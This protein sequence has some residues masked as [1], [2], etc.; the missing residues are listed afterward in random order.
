MINPINII[1]EIFEKAQRLNRNYPNVVVLATVSDNKPNT[2]CVLIKEINE[3]GFVFYTN[4]ESNK[5]KE[6]EKNPFVSIVFF[7]EELKTQIRIKGIAEKVSK[8]KSEEYFKSRPKG[9][10]IATIISK[11]SKELESYEKLIEEFEKLLEFYKDKEVEKPETWG[12]YIIKPFEIEIW[13]EGK[14]RLHKRVLYIKEGN[15]WKSK[16][17]YP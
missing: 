1:K 12:G 11:Q 16:F 7:W 8:E 14:H 15:V 3:E 17:L 2:R 9:N 13:E 4:Y 5:G 10:Q 6:I